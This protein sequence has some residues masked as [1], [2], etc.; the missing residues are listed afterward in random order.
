MPPPPADGAAPP[1][2]LTFVAARVF[3]VPPATRHACIRML[4]HINELPWARAELVEQGVRLFSLCST[5][6]SVAKRVCHNL[7]FNPALLAQFSERELASLPDEA[8]QGAALRRF[9]REELE[10]SAAIRAMLRERY[11]NVNATVVKSCALRCR[12]CGSADIAW[13]QKQTRGA[14]ESMTIFCTCS[15][16]GSKWKMS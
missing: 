11:D 10:R 12:S 7:L 8:M 6:E 14:D 16:C 1:A 3:D 13:Q 9:Q 4:M 5:Y 15:A 2:T